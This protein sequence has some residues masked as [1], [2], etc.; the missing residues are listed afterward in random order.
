[1]EKIVVG[2]GSRH[3]VFLDTPVAHNLRGIAKALGRRVSDL[4]VVVLDRPRHA[5]LIDEIRGAGARIQLIADGDLSALLAAVGAPA[6]LA[7]TDRVFR[8]ALG[9]GDLKLAV[10]L[11]LMFGVTQLMIGFLLGTVAFAAVVL[12]LVL[13]RRVT[14][15]TRQDR[16]RHHLR[17]P[18]RHGL[19]VFDHLRPLLPYRGRAC[20]LPLRKGP[21]A[22][23]R[24]VQGDPKPENIGR[25]ARDAG[26]RWVGLLGREVVIGT[27]HMIKPGGVLDRPGDRQV[28]QPRGRSHDDVARFDVEMDDALCPQVVQGGAQFQ[29]KGQQLVEGQWAV[30]PQQAGQAWAV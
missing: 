9:M 1:M 16:V 27:G 4:V 8:G 28:D 18:A 13:G 21:G 20:S 23:Q 2:P 22:G 29:T 25:V 3:A 26:A 5:R 12:V 6:L 10:S 11:G 30:A 17:D 15:K 19:G 14:L 7:I 24:F